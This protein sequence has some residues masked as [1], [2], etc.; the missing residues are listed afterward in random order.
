VA[1]ARWW[2]DGLQSRVVRLLIPR[3]ILHAP[4]LEFPSAGVF[5]FADEIS[6]DGLVRTWDEMTS[7]YTAYRQRLTGLDGYF[8][9]AR[10]VDNPDFNVRDHVFIERLP[11]GRNG[12]RELEELMAAFMSKPWDLKKPLW[13]AKVVYNYRDDTGAR[14]ALLTRAHHSAF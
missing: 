4:E 7:R 5:T 6:Y 1:A 11:H 12:K 13:E 3:S 10:L 8:H 9:S 14:S 2:T